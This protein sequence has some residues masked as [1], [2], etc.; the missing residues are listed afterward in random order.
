ML[1][2]LLLQRGTAAGCECTGQNHGINTAQYGPNYGTSC[3]AWDD[4][5]TY[6]SNLKSCTTYDEDAVG[7]YCCRSW[8]YIDATTCNGT[9]TNFYASYAQ[10]GYGETLFYSYDACDDHPSQEVAY[11]TH[12][13]CP[14]KGVD[15]YKPS[16]RVFVKLRDFD[17]NAHPHFGCNICAEPQG[18]GGVMFGM[19]NST[20]GSDGKPQLAMKYSQSDRDTFQQWY[21][22]AVCSSTAYLTFDW[23]PEKD[24]HR[25][26]SS[27]YLPL[28]QLLHSGSPKG[29]FTTEM[30]IFFRYNG[31]EV[32]DFR[33]DDDVWVFINNH[34]V[35]DIGGCHPPAEGS[36]SLDNVSADIGLVVGRTYKLALFQAERCYGQ[37][38]FKAEMT[39]RPDQGICPGQCNEFNE[40]GECNIDTGVCFCYGGWTGADCATRASGTSGGDA[41]EEDCER[42]AYDYAPQDTTALPTTTAE[43]KVASTARAPEVAIGAK[44]LC[45]ALAGA[46][47]S[48]QY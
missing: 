34:L 29:L 18:G 38:N 9:E 5:V 15:L 37:S 45:T 6:D 36:V 44:V 7:F 40:Q 8:C 12:E 30:S 42:F 19:V 22:D 4:G 21:S 25:F 13:A 2:A 28:Q 27:D 24:V 47:W 16:V 35:I 14:F 23:A 31:G 43:E 20:L 10:E 46:V 1:A 32:F 48:S 33:G 3:K 39:L 17:A 11:A 41:E 26:E